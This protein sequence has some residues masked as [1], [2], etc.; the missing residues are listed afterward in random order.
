M[1]YMI[2]VQLDLMLATIKKLNK[3]LMANANTDYQQL[4]EACKS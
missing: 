1:C 2:P 4:S 3:N